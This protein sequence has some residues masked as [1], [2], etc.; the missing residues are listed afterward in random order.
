MGQGSS[1]LVP[2]PVPPGSPRKPFT[3]ADEAKTQP[4]PHVKA[5]WSHDWIYEFCLQ[6]PHCL[7]VSQTRIWACSMHACMHACSHS[8][9]VLI[10]KFLMC[11]L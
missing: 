1:T 5:E 3:W 2:D 7:G 6:L 11:D 10:S 4:K 8:P 9:Y